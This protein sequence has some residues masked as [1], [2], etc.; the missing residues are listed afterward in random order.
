[1]QLKDRIYKLRTDLHMAREQFADEFGISKQAVQKWENGTATPDLSKFI[2]M[3][4]R[5]DISLDALILDRE[6]FLSNAYGLRKALISS[7]VDG[8]VY[9]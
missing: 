1:M 9:G 2:E 8:S 4:K 3:S 7:N 6:S 5:F